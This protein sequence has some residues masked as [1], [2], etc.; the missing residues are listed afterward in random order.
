MLGQQG[1]A[2]FDRL[3]PYSL[4]GRSKPLGVGFET[5]RAQARLSG[6]LF[7]VPENPDIELSATSS[8]P[9]LPE[10]HYASH[11]NDNE[12]NL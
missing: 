9:C 4:V 11:N 8:V 2:L 1:A 5:P 10:C 6:S 3:R 7:L 12:M